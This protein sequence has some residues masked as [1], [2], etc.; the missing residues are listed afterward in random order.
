MKPIP[1]TNDTTVF[2]KDQ[3]E[4]LPLPAY[5]HNDEMKCVSACWY[6][7]F[8]ERV[9]ILFTGRIYTTLPTFGKP[10]TPQNN[11]IDACIQAHNEAGGK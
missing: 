1:F 7:S 6:L 11:M 5:R 9:K 4:Y 2:A 10:L 8:F 3:P